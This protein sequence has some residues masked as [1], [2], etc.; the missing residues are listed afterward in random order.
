MNGHQLSNISQ[1]RATFRAD[2]FP[3]LGTDG[4]LICRTNEDL[5]RSWLLVNE[6][7]LGRR[8]RLNLCGEMGG[9]E[10][11]LAV[12]LLEPTEREVGLVGLSTAPPP[13]D[14]LGMAIA[15]V[16]PGY[17]FSALVLNIVVPQHDSMGIRHQVCSE[18]WEFPC[19]D[20]LQ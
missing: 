4:A 18:C 15:F 16:M 8:L 2:V 13:G 10:L 3:A 17:L 1:Q 12:C 19:S 20:G 9:S 6:T 14:P 7:L 5:Q 11:L